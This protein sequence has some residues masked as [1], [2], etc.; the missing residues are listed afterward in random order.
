MRGKVFLKRIQ[1]T[2][3]P[4]WLSSNPASIREDS[5]SIPGPAQWVKDPVLPYVAL[6]PSR[7]GCGVGRWL[8][9]GFDP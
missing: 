7:C 8:Q 2:E 3:L 6:I 9:L 5:G 1:N 4:W